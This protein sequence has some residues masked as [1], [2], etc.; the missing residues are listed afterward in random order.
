M[1][2]ILLGGVIAPLAAPLIFLLGTLVVSI[3]HDGPAVGLHDWQAALALV[4]V[5]VLPVSYLATW[6][7]GV[8][9][10]YWL[11]STSRLTTMN[12][13]VG[14]VIFGVVSAWTYQWFGKAGALQIGH[15]AL[16]A[17]LGVGLAL[18][19]AIAF[20][21]VVGTPLGRAE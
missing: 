7:L 18:C 9:Y 10:I 8:P 12:V 14:A 16:G 6:V 15:L 17:L 13:C 19:V 11:R 21:G 20:C 5:F 4:A 1:R 2:S 3:V